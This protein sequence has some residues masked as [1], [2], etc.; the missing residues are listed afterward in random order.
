MIDTVPNKL[1]EKHKYLS[2][3]EGGAWLIKQLLARVKPNNE[4]KSYTQGLKFDSRPSS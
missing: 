4:P 1:N 2:P 3:R